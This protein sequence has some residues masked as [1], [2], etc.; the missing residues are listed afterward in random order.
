MCFLAQLQIDVSSGEQQGGTRLQE[1]GRVRLALLRQGVAHL[2]LLAIRS[3]SSS[4]F[5]DKSKQRDEV[6]TFSESV[7]LETLF[8]QVKWS[9]RSLSRGALI[10]KG[11]FSHIYLPISYSEGIYIFP[12]GLCRRRWDFEAYKRQANFECLFFLEDEFESKY[13]GTIFVLESFLNGDFFF[14]FFFFFLG[15]FSY[16]KSLNGDSRFV[17]K[18]WKICMPL[19]G[20]AHTVAS[21]KKETEKVSGWEKELEKMREFS[22]AVEERHFIRK[23]FGDVQRVLISKK[24]P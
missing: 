20:K 15:R 3:A 13:F 6:V 24:K 11:T 17:F 22:G 4:V 18:S 19:G 23:D 8:L 1:G 2:R 12:S 5:C 7:T 14:F 21:L 9:L 16:W 10:R